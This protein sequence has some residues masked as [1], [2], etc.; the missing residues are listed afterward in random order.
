MRIA[1]LGAT[2]FIGRH[3]T[4]ALAKRDLD[5]FV[6]VRKTPESCPIACRMVPDFSDAAMLGKAIYDCDVVV[7]LADEAGRFDATTGSPPIAT[8]LAEALIGVSGSS[9]PR[10]IFASSIYARLDEEG[11]SN[12]YGARK[13]QQEKV[14]L[15][16]TPAIG[17]RLP[18]VYG[19]GCGGSFAMLD[20]AIKAGLPLPLGRATA[21]RSYLS[22]DNLCD[23][24]ATLL[25]AGDAAW[26]VGAPG[27]Y[28]PEDP[29]RISARNLAAA[30][31][32][33][34]GS[35][36]RLLPVPRWLLA[37]LAAAIGRGELIRGA[38]DPLEATG[39]PA[40]KRIFSWQPTQGLPDTLVQGQPSL[41]V[42]SA[43]S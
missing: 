30:L 12:P 22:V 39:N 37:G 10:L 13:R 33:H 21:P 15:A 32:R 42:T 40:L 38:F 1:V 41:G 27:L 31:A 16:A 28:E 35:P 19:E 11:Q 5:A 23:L 20:K 2:G 7:H 6:I 36:S 26:T 3:L 4:A 8:S 25:T 17:L 34:H 24:I 29:T 18:P 14:L 9:H 43:A